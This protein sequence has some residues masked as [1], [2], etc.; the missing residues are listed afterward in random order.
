MLSSSLSMCVFVYNICFSHCLFCQQLTGGYIVNIPCTLW[1][2]AFYLHETKVEA[3]M[4]TYVI[5]VVDL[6]VGAEEE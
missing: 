5:L 4:I 6:V 2:Y 1:S 3:V